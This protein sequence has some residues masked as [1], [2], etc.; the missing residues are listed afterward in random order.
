MATT[1]AP[2]DDARGATARVAGESS[3]IC[4]YM[5]ATQAET[6]LDASFPARP[7]QLPAI[8]RAVGDAA[9]RFGADET[10]LVQIT[11]AVTEAATNAIVHAY[12]DR[13]RADAGEVQVL[14]LRSA[15]RGIDI[16]VRDRGIGPT[17]R[18]DSPGLGL[19]LSLMAHESDDFAI[20]AA[21]GGGTE[22][23]LHYRM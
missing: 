23:W 8:R 20:R 3:G 9:R 21:P 22:V 10:V 5:F 15:E 11:L 2:A 13:P 14:V 18:P 19:G 16:H 12:R 4:V 17:P 7:S 1:V 6:A